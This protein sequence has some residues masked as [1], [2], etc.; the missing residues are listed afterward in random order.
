MSLCRLYL[1]TL[2]ELLR[3]IRIKQDLVKHNTTTRVSNMD[4]LQLQVIFIMLF[5]SVVYRGKQIMLYI[6]M[7]NMRRLERGQR[8]HLREVP[9]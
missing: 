4:F 7:K 9:R 8:F 6:L 3:K 1:N 5:T 2:T